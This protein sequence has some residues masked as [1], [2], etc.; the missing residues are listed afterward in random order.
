MRD[1]AGHDAVRA[2][3]TVVHAAGASVSKLHVMARAADPKGPPRVCFLTLP[4]EGLVGIH[5][6]KRSELPRGG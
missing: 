4:N 5:P 3:L 1:T 6:P 2:R